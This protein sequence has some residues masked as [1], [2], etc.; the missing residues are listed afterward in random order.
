MSTNTSRPVRRTQYAKLKFREAKWNRR[1]RMPRED[2]QKNKKND[3]RRG[4][5]GLTFSGT[6]IKSL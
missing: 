2:I 5:A 6:T 1:L 4:H 3:R